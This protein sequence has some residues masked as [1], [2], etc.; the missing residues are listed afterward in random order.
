MIVSRSV[1]HRAVSSLYTKQKPNLILNVDGLIGVAFVDLL[2]TCGGFT[3]LEKELS[4]RSAHIY[5]NDPKFKV[6]HFSYC[7]FF[8]DFVHHAGMRLMSL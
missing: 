5:H 3:R 2:R 8:S 6:T 1:C 4:S 7:A